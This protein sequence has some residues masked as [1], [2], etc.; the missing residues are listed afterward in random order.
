MESTEAYI[1]LCAIGLLVFFAL[2]LSAQTKSEDKQI[3][4]LIG[5]YTTT[6]NRADEALAETVFSNVTFIHPRG[7]ERGQEQIITNFIKMR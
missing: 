6:I 7:E 4:D 5:K 2:P 3:R 1:P